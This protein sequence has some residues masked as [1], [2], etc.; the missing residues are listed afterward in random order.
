MHQSAGGCLSDM[1]E[2]QGQAKSLV[3]CNRCGHIDFHKVLHL[4]ADG[5]QANGRN[6]C[7]IAELGEKATFDN[8]ALC[9]LCR[10]FSMAEISPTSSPQGLHLRAFSAFSPTRSIQLKHLPKTL[11]AADLPHLAVISS[12]PAS[13]PTLESGAKFL[14]CSGQFEE[15]HRIFQ[16]QTLSHEV[17]Y[18]SIIANLRF[19]KLRH[20]FRVAGKRILLA[21]QS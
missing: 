6:G 21:R 8:L 7:L 14:L 1:K 20:K 2:T 19:C 17:D 11:L 9:V 13:N 10:F 3:L 12:S 16:P 4:S 15:S 5:L 18:A